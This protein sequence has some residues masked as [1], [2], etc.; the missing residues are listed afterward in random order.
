MKPPRFEYHAPT[1][2]AE[3]LELLDEHGEEAK[4]LAGGQSLV[5]LL[6]FRLAR[7]DRLI[8]INRLG[9]LAQIRRRAE[10]LHVGA[11]TRQAVLERSELVAL[12]YPLLREAL[13]LVA[14]A[15]IR[16]RGTVG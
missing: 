12:H 2:L 9:E 15:Q 1:T 13:G 11:L 5:P 10:H 14:H 8:D 7:P 4:V 3:A 6:N 16:N